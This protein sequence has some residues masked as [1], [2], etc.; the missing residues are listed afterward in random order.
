MK[1]DNNTGTNKCLKNIQNWDQQN[2][3]SKWAYDT[4]V[5]ILL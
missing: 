2:M 4:N 5:Y 1:Q 3:P